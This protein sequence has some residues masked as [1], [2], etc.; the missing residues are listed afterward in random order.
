MNAATAKSGRGTLAV[1]GAGGHAKV[2]LSAL[3]SQS[4]SDIEVFDDVQERWGRFLLG[5]RVKG[6]F[7]AAFERGRTKGIVAVGG[8]QDRQRIVGDYPLK[9]IQ[10]IHP[11]AYVDATATVGV[12]TVV[13]ANAVIQTEAKIGSHVI[14]NS[15]ATV[16]HDCTVADF[17]HLAPGVHLGGNVRVGE[18]VLLGVGCSVKP[19]VTIGAWTV[20]GCGAAVCS[21]VPAGF[22]VAGVPAKE[23]T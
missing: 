23:L 12:G 6:S 9:W 16:D 18:G 21:D 17:A 10:V 11:S 5:C 15:A 4:Q 2:V 20:V 19:G 8:N 22:T 13:L 3:R 1:L 14:V 7:S